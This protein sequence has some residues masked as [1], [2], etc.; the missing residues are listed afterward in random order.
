MPLQESAY[1]IQITLQDSDGNRAPFTTYVGGNSI[2]ADV[3]QRANNLETQLRLISGCQIV[4]SSIT[5]RFVE[6]GVL[7]FATGA[8]VEDKGKFSFTLADGRYHSVTVPGLKEAYIYPDTNQINRV[9]ADVS[10]FIALLLTGGTD[11]YGHLIVKITDAVEIGTKGPK[12][13]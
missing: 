5:K 9:N 10:A 1:T 3:E 13:R 8:E 11:A 7:V 2:F 12:R 4:E 6:T